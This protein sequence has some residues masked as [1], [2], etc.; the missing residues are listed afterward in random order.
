MRLRHLSVAAWVC[1][2]SAAA[3]A[4]GGVEESDERPLF[5]GVSLAGWRVVGPAQWR[6]EHGAL[7]GEPGLG[8]GFLLTE[9]V[10]ANYRLVVEFEVE[11]RTNS[12]VF[13]H[14]E[15]AGEISPATCY[16]INIWDD[17]PRQEHRTGAIVAESGPPLARV[18]SVGRANRYEIV[19]TARR[20]AVTLNGAPTALLELPRRTAGR[21]AVQRAERG[22]VVFS[23]IAIEPLP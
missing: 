12:G 3:L 14:C 10:Y 22:R 1:L 23:K 4:A 21:I 17:H 16:E 9:R 2:G 11:A 13:I 15:D 6:V 19:A 5:D 18:D 7:L 8:D 20:V